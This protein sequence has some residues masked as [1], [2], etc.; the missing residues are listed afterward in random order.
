MAGW[1]EV[2]ISDWSRGIGGYLGGEIGK[3]GGSA[4][5]SEVV[6]TSK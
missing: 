4:E 5:S 1:M 6:E 2:V 3:T